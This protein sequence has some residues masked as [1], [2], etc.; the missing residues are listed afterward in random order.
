MVR[1]SVPIPANQPADTQR[2]GA[3]HGHNTNT[4]NTHTNTHGNAA[5]KK[6][7]VVRSS[8]ELVFSC[9]CLVSSLLFLTLPYQ[10]NQC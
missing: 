5:Q 8:L 6:D 4:H 1:T 9:T 2:H 3:Q 10:R 7:G